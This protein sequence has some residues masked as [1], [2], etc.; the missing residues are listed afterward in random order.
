FPK[1]GK[2]KA[3]FLLFVSL[4]YNFGCYSKAMDGFHLFFGG[5]RGTAVRAGIILPYVLLCTLQK[6]WRGVI[7]CLLAEICVA[8]TFYGAGYAAVTVGI[9]LVIRFV[10]QVS[11]RLCQRKKA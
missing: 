11:I 10:R 2:K 7:L 9:V 6:K 8:W 1:E 4:V 3:I 5:Y